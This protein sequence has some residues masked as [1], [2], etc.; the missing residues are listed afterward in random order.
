M[1]GPRDRL[2]QMLREFVEGRNRRVDFAAEI[3]AAIL[4]GIGWTEDEWQCAV[5]AHFAAGMFLAAGEGSMDGAQV[6]GAL[7][8]LLSCLEGDVD[9]RPELP[10]WR[11][12]ASD[13]ASPGQQE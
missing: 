1:N 7:A 12:G 4:D 8:S 5:Q 11:P 13:Q 2:A 3:A 6:A 10:P 9:F